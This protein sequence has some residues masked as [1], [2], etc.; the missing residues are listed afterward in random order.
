MLPNIVTKQ[1]HN[2]VRVF[3]PCFVC[4]CMRTQRPHKDRQI[5]SGQELDQ[6]SFSDVL[7][8]GIGIRFK[9]GIKRRFYV[10]ISS[11]LGQ[12]EY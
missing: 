3:V 8:L 1:L 10:R 11:H 9:V 6:L 2:V 5:G 4:T 12:K 7:G